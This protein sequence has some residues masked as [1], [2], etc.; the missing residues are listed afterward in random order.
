MKQLG[1][2]KNKINITK[3]KIYRPGCKKGFYISKHDT[4]VR[5]IDNKLFRGVVIV[6]DYPVDIEE[7]IEKIRLPIVPAEV[8]EKVYEFFRYVYN[9][10]GTESVILL[11]HNF[12]TGMWTVEVPD[13]TV[14]G[15]AIDYERLPEIDIL[16][17][18]KGYTLVGTIH[19]HGAMPAFHSGTD[20]KDEFMF[21]GLHVTIGHVNSTPEFSCRFI[22]KDIEL[23]KDAE[24][25]IEI[26]K[27]RYNV[28]EEWR[29]HVKKK[30]YTNNYAQNN[31][32]N[33][34]LSMYD[35]DNQYNMYKK[36]LGKVTKTV[37]K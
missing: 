32:N 16:Y 7:G 19:S 8:I 25:V 9:E 4:I 5:V 6:D 12:K 24:D 31:Y 11:W 10:Y 15:A 17:R 36:N 35:E 29:K 22:M 2:K 27:F 21:D 34:F 30:T 18:N 14:T 1:K 3:G 28:D 20:D 37:V 33:N 26:P 13:Q 23:K